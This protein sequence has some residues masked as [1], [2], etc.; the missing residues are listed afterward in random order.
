[1]TGKQRGRAVGSAIRDNLVDILHVVKQSHPYD[2]YKHYK[3][4]FGP[5]CIRSIYYNLTKGK[6]LGVFRIKEIQKVEGDFSWGPSAQRIIFEL[7]DKATPK[8]NAQIENTL[9][10]PHT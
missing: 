5:V 4:V 1:M 8:T 6:E 3:N 9:G 2:L 10:K 7:G